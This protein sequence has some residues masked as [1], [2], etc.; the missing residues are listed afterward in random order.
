MDFKC[1]KCKCEEYDKDS[2]TI[3]SEGLGKIFDPDKKLY[4]ISCKECGY[5]E[6]YKKTNAKN[7]NFNIFDL[8]KNNNND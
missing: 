7:I 2:F 5:T 8:F 6:F 3:P 4:M 1:I